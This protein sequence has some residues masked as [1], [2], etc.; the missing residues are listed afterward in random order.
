MRGTLLSLLF[1]FLSWGQQINSYRNPDKDNPRRRDNSS[2]L[3][4]RNV[5][6]DNSTL[7]DSW[8]YATVSGTGKF[9]PERDSCNFGRHSRGSLELDWKSR[10]CFCDNDCSLYG[11]CCIDARVFDNRLQKENYGLFG[12]VHLRQYGDIYMRETCA[13]DWDLPNIRQACTNTNCANNNCADPFGSLP[14]T[15]RESGV[16]YRNYYCAVCNRAGYGVQF[17]KPRLECPTLHGYNERFKNITDSYLFQNL[18]QN[19]AGQWGVELDDLGGGIS[20]F[21]D[22][23]I[24]PYVPSPELLERS[25]RKCN[26]VDMI[27]SCPAEF[28]DGETVRLCESYTGVMYSTG[29][30]AYRNV[31]CALCNSVT[32]SDL[33]CLNLNNMLRSGF[34]HDFNPH[35]FAVLFDIDRNSVDNV[36]VGQVAPCGEGELWDPFFRKCRNVICGEAGHLFIRGQ[37]YPPGDVPQETTEDAIVTDLLV[38]DPVTTTEVITVAATQTMET[39]TRFSSQTTTDSSSIRFP[40][41]LTTTKTTTSTTTTTTTISTTSRPAST[42]SIASIIFPVT[43]STMSSTSSTTSTTTTTTTSDPPS[44]T[45]DGFRQCLKFS[46]SPGEFRLTADGIYI[47]KWDKILSSGQYRVRGESVNVCVPESEFSWTVGKFSPVMGYVTVSCLG[48]SLLC[49]VLHLLATCLAPELQNLSGK[50]L[51]SFSISLLSGYT[52]FLLNMFA[53]TLDLLQ[54]SIVAVVMYYSFLSS[55]FWM[56][57]ISFDVARTLKLAATELRL[58]SG[59]QWSSYFLY[60]VIGWGVPAAAAVSATVIDLAEI[61]AVPDNYRPGFVSSYNSST[62]GR[63]DLCWFSSRDALLVYFVLPFAGIMCLNIV[64]FVSS[65]FL[66]WEATRSSAKITTTGPRTNFLLYLRLGVLMGMTWTTGLVAGVVDKEEVWYTFMVL[67]SLQ[68]LFIL[69]F[70]SCTKKVLRS[71]RDRLCRRG[72][73]EDDTWKCSNTSGRKTSQDTVRHSG[74]DQYHKYDQRYY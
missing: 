7:G 18:K 3:G 36:G 41:I 22:C 25:V 70:F 47:P 57:V 56:L 73:E 8:D 33:I 21:H 38:T 72:E 13:D 28:S 37:C 51:A 23:F 46:L 6:G 17:W 31:H 12:C 62:T 49:L 11:D 60:C 69:L 65:A 32:V 15:H 53:S 68:G 27:H 42:S 63:T 40:T 45:S 35:S 66:V 1:P 29:D 34:V 48:V 58:S 14:V 24:D 44:S 5:Q 59:G 9:C 64:F 4:P 52:C 30:T 20:V 54:C 61:A 2:Q 26:N 55:F 67:N 39:T 50:N 10:N 43:T 71:V 16:T 19:R 74:Y